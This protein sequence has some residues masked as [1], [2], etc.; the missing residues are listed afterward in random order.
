MR[1]HISYETEEQRKEILKMLR[2]IVNKPGVRI[3]DKMQGL[4][5]VERRKHIYI[6]M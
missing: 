3:W 5:H 4:R 2:P 6:T 1:I